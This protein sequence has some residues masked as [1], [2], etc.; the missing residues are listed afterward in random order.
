M[1][2]GGKREGSGRKK[3]PP[4]IKRKNW[5]A[6]L[7]E[8]LINELEQIDGSKSAKTEAA[9]IGYYNLKPPESQT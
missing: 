1:S 5:P 6:T 8:W 3:A 4:G 7:P 2:W 9:L